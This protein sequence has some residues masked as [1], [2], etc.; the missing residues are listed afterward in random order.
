MPKC[1]GDSEAALDQISHTK[2]S[3]KT[4]EKKLEQNSDVQS[5]LKFARIWTLSSQS[6]SKKV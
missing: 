1:R 3:D 6:Q 2:H 5:I 4:L